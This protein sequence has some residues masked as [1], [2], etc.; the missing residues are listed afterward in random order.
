MGVRENN[1]SKFGADSF[2]KARIKNF[3]ID[4]EPLMVMSLKKV[5]SLSELA[6]Y[7]ADDVK[8]NHRC[9]VVSTMTYSLYYSQLTG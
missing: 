2:V 7:R 6:V 9:H 1:C 8:D 4:Y 5:N 3:Y